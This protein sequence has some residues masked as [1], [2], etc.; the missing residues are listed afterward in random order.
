MVSM[1][2]K[3]SFT[4][5]VKEEY[6]PQQEDETAD[7]RGLLF[8]AITFLSVV[9]LIVLGVFI[10]KNKSYQNDLQNISQT[11]SAIFNILSPSPPDDNQNNWTSYSDVNFTI[12]YPANWVAKKVFLSK[13]DLVIYDP[14]QIKQEVE[15]GQEVQVLLAYIDILQIGTTTKDAQKLAEDYKEQMRQ[16]GIIL[17]SEQSPTLG[18]NL[19]LV[20]NGNT[21]TSD[22]NVFLTNNNMVAVFKTSLQHLTD[23]ST[24][25]QILR[26]FMFIQSQ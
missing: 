21:E 2:E 25:N 22:N 23:N 7:S 17:Q 18:T 20:S 9:F 1:E 13:T 10:W 19:V 26:T 15:N 3:I 4:L 11:S 12:K 6:T 16:K 5:N 24:E 8:T 14:N